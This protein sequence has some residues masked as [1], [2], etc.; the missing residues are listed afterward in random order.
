MKLPLNLTKKFSK[1]LTPAKEK[2]AQPKSMLGTVVKNGDNTFVILDGSTIET[3]VEL[4]VDAEDGD[5]VAVQIKNHKAMVVSNFTAPPSSRSATKYVELTDDGLLIGNLFGIDG[6]SLLVGTDKL[7]INNVDGEQSFIVQLEGVS[8][9]GGGKKYGFRVS[10]GDNYSYVTSVPE[11]ADSTY[12]AMQNSMASY[13]N[14]VTGKAGYKGYTQTAADYAYHV[15]GNNN[16]FGYRVN[17]NG[18]LSCAS[19][20][21]GEISN[22][23]LPAGTTVSDSETFNHAFTSAPIVVAGLAVIQL[24]F[25]CLTLAIVL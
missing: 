21:S 10:N 16:A 2:N 15:S 12:M 3:P 13:T 23:S 4:A 7:Y 6:T 20:D 5:R 24:V 9:P 22:I 19:L 14:T 17:W 25:R 8:Y 1:A 11:A 18:D